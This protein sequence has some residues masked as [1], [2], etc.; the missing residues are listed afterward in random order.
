MFVGGFPCVLG[1]A[2]SRVIPSLVLLEVTLLNLKETSGPL[3]PLKQNYLQ[4]GPSGVRDGTDLFERGLKI[5]GCPPG[6]PSNHR[7]VSL[8]HQSPVS[9]MS[10]LEAE[11][12]VFFNRALSAGDMYWG[13]ATP[14]SEGLRHKEQ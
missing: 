10:D 7:G 2:I 12:R 13:P 14:L 11:R 9:S 6:R 8:K 1:G 5:E 4:E 3:A